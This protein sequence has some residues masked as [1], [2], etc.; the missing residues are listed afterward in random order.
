MFGLR[1]PEKKNPLEE[2]YDRLRIAAK[3]A[4]KAGD[5][6]QYQ[7]LIAETNQALIEMFSSNKKTGTQ[8]QP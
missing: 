1:K 6:Q 8:I 5:L 3:K 7:S 4:Y 2:K